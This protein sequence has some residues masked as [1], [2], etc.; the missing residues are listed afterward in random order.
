MHH[1]GK[2]NFIYFR[3]VRI[4]PLLLIATALLC[5]CKKDS[6]KKSDTSVTDQ[7]P[8]TNRVVI[9][10]SIEPLAFQV[11][12]SNPKHKSRYLIL[13]AT[14]SPGPK[15]YSVSGDGTSLTL[16]E[17]DIGPLKLFDFCGSRS[18]G[19]F[20]ILTASD[21]PDLVTQSLFGWFYKYDNPD[22]AFPGCYD[23]YNPH[24]YEYGEIPLAVQKAVNVVEL[25]KFDSSGQL[26]W[27]KQIPGVCSHSKAIETD[28]EGNVYL[29]V[30]EKRI[31]SWKKV[32]S[33]QGDYYISAEDSNKITLYKFS[34][35]GEQLFQT[36]LDVVIK[37]RGHEGLNPELA[38]TKG[39]VYVRT[40]TDIAAFST[41]GR[42]A[43]SFLPGIN[44]CYNLP[45]Q[46]FANPEAFDL[47]VHGYL[48]DDLHASY[49]SK[50][51]TTSTVA[52]RGGLSHSPNLF[53]RDRAGNLFELGNYRLKKVTPGGDEIYGWDL[54]AEISFQQ[55]VANQCVVDKSG[56]LTWFFFEGE[57]LVM[58]QFR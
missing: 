58:K 4:L 49:L 3:I 57:K 9:T 38:V 45:L 26:T 44:T 18:D 54:T 55:P 41:N 28:S 2:H 15:V 23:L 24:K 20:Y 25:R 7:E 11:A 17:V 13:Q 1:S 42:Y 46:L 10:G 39:A 33:L 52:F 31:S 40:G 37:V 29:V 43:G 56:L 27:V 32:D 8:W 51:Y 22:A 30:S 12:V 6:K 16:P 5:S 48:G 50:V 14:A 19:S 36:S 21:H 53:G 35:A 47:I 34:A